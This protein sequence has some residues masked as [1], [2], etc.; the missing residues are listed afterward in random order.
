MEPQIDVAAACEPTEAEVHAEMALLFD[1][2]D[3]APCVFA[4]TMACIEPEFYS[5]TQDF[6]KQ[7]KFEPT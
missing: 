1:A 5:H 6:L 2:S 4:V 7:G 3:Q